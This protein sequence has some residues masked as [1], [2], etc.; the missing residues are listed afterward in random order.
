MNE[1]FGNCKKCKEKNT[2]FKWCRSCNSKRLEA[3]FPTWTSGNE[4]IDK[5][6][7]ETQLTARCWQDVFEWIPYTNISEVEEVG[8]G[9]YG[10]VYKSKWEGGCIIKWKSKEKKWERWGTEYVAL[11]T[12]NGDLDEFM[13][14][15][16]EFLL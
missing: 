3:E 10:T 5:F 12:L 6:L 8:K 4:R 1:E 9:G 11:K 2:G 16:S 14:E 15:V 13:H 7:R